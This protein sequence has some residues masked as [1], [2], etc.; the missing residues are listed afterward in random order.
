[1]DA[2]VARPSVFRDPLLERDYLRICSRPASFVSRTLAAGLLVV[3]AGIVLVAGRDERPDVIGARLHDVYAVVGAIVAAW[4]TLSETSTA[5]PVE[6]SAGTLPLLL[7]SPLSTRRLAAGFLGSRIAYAGTV[8][9]ALLPIEGLSLLLGGVSGRD[10][11]LSNATIAMAAAWAGGVGL[12]AS[13]G[14]AE[15]RRGL[16]SAITLAILWA[17]VVPLLLAFVGVLLS[18]LNG[19]EAWRARRRSMTVTG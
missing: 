16:G 3:A 5:I 9:I 15:A 2:A 1:M 14:A 7:A 19:L 6:R 17:G 18:E 10:V 4:M 8:V 13:A 11:L 12:L